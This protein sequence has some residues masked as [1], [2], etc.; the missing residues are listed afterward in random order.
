MAEQSRVGTSEMDREAG[1]FWQ[2]FALAGTVGIL[3][4]ATVWIWMGFC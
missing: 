1:R 4:A 2:R 3:L